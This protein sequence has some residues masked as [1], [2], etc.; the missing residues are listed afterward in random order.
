MLCKKDIDTL[1]PIYPDVDWSKTIWSFIHYSK[2]DPDSDLPDDVD[3]LI[4]ISL[5]HSDGGCLF[6]LSFEWV[7]M[8]GADVPRLTCFNDALPALLTPT[9]MEVIQKLCTWKDTEFTPEM[10]VRL[11]TE[12]GFLDRSHDSGDKPTQP[13]KNTALMAEG[14]LRKLRCFQCTL[15]R[16]I[17]GSCGKCRLRHSKSIRYIP[18]PN[19]I[20]RRKE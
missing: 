2:T 8:S 5:E 3:D 17:G 6:E 15:R 9:L 11:L 1:S 12:A 16:S 19:D 20:F 7:W 4:M 18:I 10:V 14:T 13:K